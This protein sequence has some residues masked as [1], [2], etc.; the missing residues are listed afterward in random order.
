[1]PLYSHNTL[2]ITYIYIHTLTISNL[3]TSPSSRP[4]WQEF[5][6][7]PL[8]SHNMLYITYIYTHTLTISNLTTSPSSRSQWQEFPYVPLYSHNMLCITY[9]YIYTHFNDQHPDRLHLPILQVLV[10]RRASC[11]APRCCVRTVALASRS[12]G[13]RP[14]PAGRSGLALTARSRWV[15]QEA[16][17]SII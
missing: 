1:M 3:T 9:I 16:A 10:A 15:Q 6:Y 14:A 5:P 7:V 13:G 2:C 12:P 8:Y 11:T 4:Q 17:L